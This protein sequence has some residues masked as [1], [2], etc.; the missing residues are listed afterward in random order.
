MRALILSALAAAAIAYGMWLAFGEPEQERVIDL[1]V[2]ER[3]A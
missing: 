2:G 1:T 3:V